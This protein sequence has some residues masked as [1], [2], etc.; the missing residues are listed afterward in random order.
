MHIHAWLINMWI[1]NCDYKISLVFY[2][3]K[4]AWTSNTSNSGYG[5]LC[6]IAE[7]I[8]EKLYFFPFFRISRYLNGILPKGPNPP[9]LRMADRALLAGYP[10]YQD[11]LNLPLL[12]WE[13][14]ST[15]ILHR[16]PHHIVIWGLLCQKLVSSARIIITSHRIWDTMPHIHDSGTKVL[17]YST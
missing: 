7:W 12:S 6:K 4:K 3:S 1:R 13:S 16:Y 17:I 11:M 14:H 9:C 8:N 15:S 10:R 5:I 2:F